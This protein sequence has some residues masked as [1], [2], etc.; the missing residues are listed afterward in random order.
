L[1][2]L[3]SVTSDEQ[4]S[5][6]Y[7]FTR[8]LGKSAMDFEEFILAASTADLIDEPAAREH[9]DAVEF[10]MDLAEE[11]RADL[12]SYSGS[13]PVIA[14]NRVTWEGGDAPDTPERLATLEAAAEHP[15]VEAIDVELAAIESED[16]GSVVE[17]AR[18]QGT[19]VVVSTHNFEATPDRTRLD[20]LLADA[21]EYGDVS[22]LA[23]TATSPDDVLDVLGATRA[24]TTEG[25]Q[26]ATMAMGEPG[27]HSRAVA[28]LYGSRIGYAPVDPA[29]ATAPGQYDLATL[30]NLVNRLQDG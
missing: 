29:E 20:S 15:L 8:E 26:V 17:Y 10:R 3:G 28:P 14:T 22:K 16:A 7:T 19:S 24:A 9:A 25:M 21:W 12:R 2:L 13:L 6:G 30:A 5:E 18:D 1:L 4:R 27:R 23:V 11:P